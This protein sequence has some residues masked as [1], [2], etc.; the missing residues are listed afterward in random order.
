MPFMIIFSR[1]KSKLKAPSETVRK[2]HY[3]KQSFVGKIPSG[4]RR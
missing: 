3:L 1:Y 4:I 2:I